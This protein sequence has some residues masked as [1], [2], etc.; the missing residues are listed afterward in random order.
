TTDSILCF[1]SRGP[2]GTMPGGSVVS[3]HCRWIVQVIRSSLTCWC[4]RR[5][6]TREVWRRRASHLRRDQASSTSERV[7]I[8]R[9]LTL[10]ATGTWAAFSLGGWHDVAAAE[11]EVAARATF[12]SA[13]AEPWNVISILT[14]DQAAWSVGAYGNRDVVTPNLDRLASEGARFTNAFT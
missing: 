7:P 11:P 4:R 13:A 9:I 12:D 14:D 6:A 3:T 1:L 10:L 2:D 5:S 8:D